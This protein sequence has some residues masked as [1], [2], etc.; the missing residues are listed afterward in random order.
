MRYLFLVIVTLGLAIPAFSD[1][2]FGGGQV[3]PQ[4][5]RSLDHPSLTPVAVSV[6]PAI[7]VKAQAN[8]YDPN[9]DSD[10]ELN[11]RVN[12]LQQ[13]LNVLSQQ[14]LMFHQQLTQHVEILSEQTLQLKLQLATVT[15]ALQ[16][17]DKEVQAVNAIGLK[18]P[19]GKTGV[20]VA[21]STSP[22]TTDH[23][24]IVARIKQKY[25]PHSPYVFLGIIILIILLL[26]YFMLPKKIQGDAIDTDTDKDT[27]EEYDFLG[28]PE[29][30]PAKLDLARAY[31]AMQDFE[32]MKAT[33]QEVIE[34]G[35]EEQRRVAQELLVKIPGES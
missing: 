26:I 30:I 11:N 34:S 3:A 12:Q 7:T 1:T 31:F 4:Q 15:R 24:S 32:Q 25:G 18:Q 19:A 6:K 21:A 35:N 8:N 10:K 28:S 16:M 14:V 20:P 2:E 33:L 9:G 13:Q 27:D 17:L 22:A 23:A 29:G 5:V